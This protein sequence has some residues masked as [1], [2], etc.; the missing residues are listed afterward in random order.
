MIGEVFG[1]PPGDPMIA[2]IRPLVDDFKN[3]FFHR[4]AAGGRAW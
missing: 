4:N 1:F 3:Y 2:D